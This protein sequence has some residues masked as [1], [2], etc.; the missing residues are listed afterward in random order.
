MKRLLLLFLLVPALSFGQKALTFQGVGHNV[1]TDSEFNTACGVNWTCGTGWTIT[2]GVGIADVS[3]NGWY[4]QQAGLTTA[5][6]IYKLTFTIVSR[7]NGGVKIR[8]G[9]TGDWGTTRS[10]VGTYTEILTSYHPAMQIA[11]VAFQGSIDNVTV[12][13]WTAAGRAVTFAGDVMTRQFSDEYQA[14]YDAFT[15]KPNDDI[16]SAQDLFV[17]TVVASGVWAKLDVFYNY[18]QTTNAGGEA[19]I[20]WPNPGTFDATAY[21][22][23]A[24]VALEGFTGAATKYIDC[25]WS[26]Y[27]NGENFTQ[28][29]ASIGVYVRTDE[30]GSYVEMGAGDAGATKR[31]TL[32][33]RYTSTYYI[34]LNSATVSSV[35]NAAAPGMY[36]ASRTAVSTGAGYKN[37]AAVITIANAST[38]LTANNLYV[39]AYNNNGSQQY[40]TLRQ[41]SMAYAGGGMTQADINSLTN[42]FEVYMDSNGKGVIP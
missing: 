28:N 36:I 29:S 27:S 6:K 1:G 4:I 17:R 38:G 23:P 34:D 21:N 35:S 18:A 9:N 3:S 7:T 32:D 12:Q 26:P 8:L 31:V 22:A 40:N 39:L 11:S 33:V 19:L 15:T 5:G 24:F 16:A 10:A 41:V 14:V 42:A 13:E 25:N 2:G 30:T 20:N 37:K